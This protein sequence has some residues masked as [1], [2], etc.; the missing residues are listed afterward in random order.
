MSWPVAGGVLLAAGVALHFLE[1]VSTLE[2]A[3]ASPGP[4]SCTIR[5]SLFH[6]VPYQSARMPSVAA[7]VA[8]P[9]RLGKVDPQ[10]VTCTSLSLMDGDGDAT[11]FV[12]LPDAE[13]VARAQRFFAD[14]S[15]ERDLRLS[16]SEPLVLAVSGAFMLAG[17]LV[18]LWAAARRRRSARATR[19][20]A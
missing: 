4:A 13:S 12:C 2:C 7:L 20:P 6:V 8:E 11:R 16:Y 15:T 5:R 18:L 3:R 19:Q 9:E 17:V 1:P 10:A 14:G